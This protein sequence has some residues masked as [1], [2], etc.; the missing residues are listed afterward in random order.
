MVKIYP[1]TPHSGETM[2]VGELREYL[3]RF[4]YDLPVAATW[5]GVVAGI[6]PENFSS[7]DCRWRYL[8]YG[9][10]I[11]ALVIDVEDYG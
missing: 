3:S 7:R 10:R 2:T 8:T 4:P 5:E 6:R 1:E 9:G 11:G